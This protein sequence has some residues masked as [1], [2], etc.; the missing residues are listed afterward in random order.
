M[1]NFKFIDIESKY[2]LLIILLLSLWIAASSYFH[3]SRDFENYN[4]WCR[5]SSLSLETAAEKDP[6]FGFSCVATGYITTDPI[7][8][9]APLW[10]FAALLLKF[11]ALRSEI[12][13]FIWSLLAYVA[14]FFVTQEMTQIRAAFASAALGYAFILIINKKKIKASILC[15]AAL[16]AHFSS[17]L[18]IPILL[19]LPILIKTKFRFIVTVATCQLVVFLSILK[20][21]LQNLVIGLLQ[22]V[23]EYDARI[24]TY[25]YSYEAD[26]VT[27][28]VKNARV[29]FFML[30][31]TVIL[32][33]VIMDDQYDRTKLIHGATGLTSI[34][35]LVLALSYTLP[36]IALRLF[37]LFAVPM[38]IMVGTYMQSIDNAIQK[39]VTSS[40]L[41]LI[42]LS[43][44]YKSLVILY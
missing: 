7:V 15:M 23:T 12:K 28:L 6:L 13:T 34:A 10:V 36:S 41:L 1:E 40:V 16:S 19:L 14:F 24:A 11:I 37:E 25:L 27:D 35:V 21:E 33:R 22:Y 20:P 26:D 3:L 8:I 30:I 29:A 31:S 17:L 5:Q 44:F 4:D 18:I 43:A 2:L 9:V 38:S 39:Q 32:T 42:L